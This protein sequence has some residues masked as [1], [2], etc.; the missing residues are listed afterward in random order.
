MLQPQTPGVAKWF[1]E[2]LDSSGSFGLQT[3]LHGKASAPDAPVTDTGC[4][5]R[6]FLR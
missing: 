5:K 2:V 3:T 6:I 4:E 1:E